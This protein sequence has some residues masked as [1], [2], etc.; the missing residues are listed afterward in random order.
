MSSIVTSNLSD[1]ER[2]KLF[3][4][5][6]EGL[7]FIHSRGF[8]HRD[9]KLQNIGIRWDDRPHAVYLDFGCATS[10]EGSIEHGVG[11]IPYLVPEVM[12]LKNGSSARPYD[13]ASDVWSLGLTLFQLLSHKIWEMTSIEKHIYEK[14][15]SSIH[16]SSATEGI[17]MKT[18]EKML[19]WGPEQRPHITDIMKRLGLNTYTCS[20]ESAGVYKRKSE[21]TRNETDNSQV[22]T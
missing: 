17:Y 22:G 20:S 15:I 11:T 8:M 1:D 16:R 2:Y 5:C 10:E 3:Q 18:V 6:I 19:A 13:K 12:A 14:I 9:I 4:Q 7:E 21:G